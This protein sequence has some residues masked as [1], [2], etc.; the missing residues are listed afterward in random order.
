MITFDTGA[1]I[2]L[3]RRDRRMWDVLDRATEKRVVITVPAPVVAEWWRA[4]SRHMGNI[5]GRCRVEDCTERLAKLTGEALAAVPRATM[6]DALVM[7]SASLRGDLVYTS[8]EDDLVRLRDARF[9]S[10]RIL[11]I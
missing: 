8:D 4:S 2:A 11:R 10:T 6:V 7:V 5:L 9:P 3:E 1:L